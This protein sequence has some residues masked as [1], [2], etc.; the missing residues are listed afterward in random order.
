MSVDPLAS[1]FHDVS[2]FVYPANNPLRFT[3]PTGMAGKDENGED[4]GDENKN[5][6]S[7]ISE[8]A[9]Q[10]SQ[11]N[12]SEEQ[13]RVIAEIFRIQNEVA[14]LKKQQP[15]TGKVATQTTAATADVASDVSM[16]FAVGGIL[17]APVTDGASLLMTAEALKIGMAADVFSTGAKTLDAL[18]FNGSPDAAK[19][20]A[21]KTAFNAAGGA[22]FKS[23]AGRVVTR[24]GLSGIGPLFRSSQTKRFVTNNFGIA[25]TAAADATSVV[26]ATQFNPFNKK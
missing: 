15:S 18:A 17:L 16:V 12:I 24:T 8:R 4:D 21:L 5:G 19:N 3:D 1:N 22:V 14:K 7:D 26:V 20:Q 10:S 6:Q 13:I 11:Q 2:P 9:A 25:V 23:V